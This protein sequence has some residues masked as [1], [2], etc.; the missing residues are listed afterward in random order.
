MKYHV[1]LQNISNKSNL[2]V[3]NK[4]VNK[5]IRHL[6]EENVVKK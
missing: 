6:Y 5:N 4:S 2:R 3:Q 1:Y